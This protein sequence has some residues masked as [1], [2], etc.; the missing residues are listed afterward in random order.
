MVLKVG[1]LVSGGSASDVA[2]VCGLVRPRRRLHLPPFPSPAPSTAESPTGLKAVAAHE[3]EGLAGIG[4]EEEHTPVRVPSLR[5]EGDVLLVVDELSDNVG[6]KFPILDDDDQRQAA[7]LYHG[8]RHGGG[9]LGSGRGLQASLG[10]GLRLYN[11][12]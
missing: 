6:G 5:G 8:C 10:S 7:S 11:K 9:R 4:G 3:Q 2:T 12:W 1:A